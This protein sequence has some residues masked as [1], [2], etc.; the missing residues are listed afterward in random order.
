MPT[1]RPE[2]ILS[3]HKV[4]LHPLIAKALK[5]AN[6]WL[7]HRFKGTYCKSENSLG[8]GKVVKANAQSWNSAHEGLEI[9]PMR[10]W[11]MLRAIDLSMRKHQVLKVPAQVCPLNKSRHLG[12]VNYLFSL[13][14]FLWLLFHPPSKGYGTDMQQPPLNTYP[15]MGRNIPPQLEVRVECWVLKADAD[16]T[17]TFVDWPY[18]L[19]VAGA[20]IPN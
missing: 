13:T 4:Y 19:T 1:K 6:E 14:Y 15:V 18:K 11:R 3:F 5:V 16:L 9:L 2:D 10:D 7:S 17:L 20:W 8:K 12:T